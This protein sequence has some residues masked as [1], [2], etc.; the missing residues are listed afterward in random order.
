MNSLILTKETEFVIYNT[1]TNKTPCPGCF[2][3]EFFQT[4]KE[5]TTP[6]LQFFS[7]AGK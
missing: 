6:S 3:G 4:V 7:E 5:E 2:T 1:L